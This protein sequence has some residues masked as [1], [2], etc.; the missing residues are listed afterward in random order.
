MKT[1][2]IMHP[3]DAKAMQMIKSVLGCERLIRVFMELGYEVQYR[4]ENLAY[5]IKVTPKSF[6]KSI[7]CLKR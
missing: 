1:T 6:P 7:V 2:D 3:E 4:G 5:Y